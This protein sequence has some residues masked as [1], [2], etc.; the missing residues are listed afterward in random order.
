M[1]S[2][3]WVG[4]KRGRQLNREVREWEDKKKKNLL[5]PLPFQNDWVYAGA[6][7]CQMQEEEITFH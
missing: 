6:S 3:S 1:E 2:N 4:Y 5:K 7:Y